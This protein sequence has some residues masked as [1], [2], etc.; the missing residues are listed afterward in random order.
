M[1]DFTGTSDLILG[2]K[3]SLSSD[4]NTRH[5]RTV[6][7]HVIMLGYGWE[8]YMIHSPTSLRK[9]IYSVLDSVLETGIPAIVERN[10]KRLK[11]VPE[12]PVGKLDRLEPHACVI[13]DSDDLAGVHWANLW[14]EE[15]ELR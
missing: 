11:I 9:S 7:T 6:Q 14:T 13:G 5:W 12:Q 15:P 10:G 8:E 4:R 3:H 2:S 1:R